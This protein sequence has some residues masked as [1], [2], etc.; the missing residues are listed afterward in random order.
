MVDHPL[1]AR[2][3][4]PSAAAAADLRTRRRERL[5][6]LDNRAL[7]ES[8]QDVAAEIARRKRDGT[9]KGLGR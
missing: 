6:Q 2:G 5:E 9:W 7:W 1:T 4:S 8:Y 3:L